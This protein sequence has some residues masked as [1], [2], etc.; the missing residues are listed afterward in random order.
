M[1]PVE[2]SGIPHQAG[3]FGFEHLP[4]RQFAPFRMMMRLGIRDALVEQ[5]G[6]SSS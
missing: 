1:E 5:P 3:A 2:A 4:D 6:I